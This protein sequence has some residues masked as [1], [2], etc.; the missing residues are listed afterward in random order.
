MEGWG[1]EGRDGEED[2]GKGED[3]GMGRRMEG[4]GGRW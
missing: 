4:W 2:G 1:G 3:G